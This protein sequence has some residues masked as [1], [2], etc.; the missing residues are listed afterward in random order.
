M[1]LFDATEGEVPP[2]KLFRWTFAGRTKF[3]NDG[4][5]GTQLIEVLGFPRAPIVILF[6]S[7]QLVCPEAVQ[8]LA[9]RVPAHFEHLCKPIIGVPSE[10]IE[11]GA[12]SAC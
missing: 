8:P 4:S 10:F 6:P 11:R 2:A 9:Q 12:R 1:G 7:V 3:L 5:H